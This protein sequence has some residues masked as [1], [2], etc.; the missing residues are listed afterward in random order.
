LHSA[1][2]DTSVRGSTGKVVTVTGIDVSAELDALLGGLNEVILNHLFRILS[3]SFR[4]AVRE[5]QAGHGRKHA[6]NR[7]NILDHF[8]FYLL[9]VFVFELKLSRDFCQNIAPISPV[10]FVES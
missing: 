3:G 2:D 4:G 8:I 5:G 9:F 1:I 6:K 10:V 7:C